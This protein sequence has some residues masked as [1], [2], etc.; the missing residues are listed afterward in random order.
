VGDVI[1]R[2]NDGAALVV[3]PGRRAAGLIALHRPSHV[4]A[5]F[6]PGQEQPGPGT[7][8]EQLKLCF[9]DLAEA[10][11]GFTAPD[12]ALIGRLL[13]FT[14]RWIGAHPLLIHCWAGIS[15]SSAA[16][17][18]VACDRNP[19]CERAIAA[20]L[21]RRAP[22]ATPNPLMVRLA[23]DMLARQGR[24][25]AAIAA[26]GRGAEATW[27]EPFCLPAGGYDHPSSDC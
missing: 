8:A 25:V 7:G 1:V 13:D 18:I 12:T 16:A 14:R 17:Y 9:H 23:D 22:F 21:R 2:A 3:G 5:C 24:M 10:R 26:I 19:G 15:R 6:A 27:G 20:D 11:A 4:V